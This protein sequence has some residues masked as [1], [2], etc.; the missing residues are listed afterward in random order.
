[1]IIILGDFNAAVGKSQ[2][3]KTVWL[4]G[5]ENQ[6]K[7]GDKLMEFTEQHELVISDSFF[8]MPKIRYYY[9]TRPTEH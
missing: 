2:D 5:L 6:N 1:M 7:R 4:Y 8:E 3:Q 9:W